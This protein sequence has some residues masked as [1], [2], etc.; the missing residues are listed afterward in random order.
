MGV[1]VVT[2]ICCAPRAEPGLS[3]TETL[4]GYCVCATEP[5]DATMGPSYFSVELDWRVSA[6]LSHFNSSVSS[7]GVVISRVVVVFNIY[8]SGIPTKVHRGRLVDVPELR[9]GRG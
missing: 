5:S 4:H 9:V 8:V 1:T 6:G 7:V 3:S 2:G